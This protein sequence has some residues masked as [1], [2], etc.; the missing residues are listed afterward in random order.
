MHDVIDD[1]WFKEKSLNNIF[2][3]LPC[4]LISTVT[5]CMLKLEDPHGKICLV[6]AFILVFRNACKKQLFL[7]S[8][9]V[10]GRCNSPYNFQSLLYSSCEIS[11]AA[12]WVVTGDVKA[13]LILEFLLPARTPGKT[14]GWV[15]DPD[16]TGGILCPVCVVRSWSAWEL[17]CFLSVRCT[18]FP[19]NDRRENNRRNSR[20]SGSG[21]SGDIKKCGEMEYI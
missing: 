20:T 19:K 1:T 21:L 4:H 17:P 5:V 8:A 14:S 9:Y 2:T 11:S 7:S 12:L 6:C 16:C 3:F 15:E 18:V 10:Y 13:L